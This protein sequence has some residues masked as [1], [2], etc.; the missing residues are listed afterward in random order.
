MISLFLLLVLLTFLLL[1]STVIE[2]NAIELASSVTMIPPPNVAYST[3]C[4]FNAWN[5]PFMSF[6]SLTKSKHLIGITSTARN[7]KLFSI[8]SSAGIENKIMPENI[9]IIGGGLAGL[10]TAYHLAKKATS[11]TRIT[12]IDREKAPGEGGASSVAGG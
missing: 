6:G 3:A 8:S 7:T 9:A 4:F 10:S 11:D 12:I 1:D 5:L 2:C